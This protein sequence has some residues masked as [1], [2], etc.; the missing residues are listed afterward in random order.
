[1]SN[2]MNKK[3]FQSLT[4]IIDKQKLQFCIKDNMV[5]FIDPSRVYMIVDKKPDYLT[6]EY[7]KKMKEMDMMILTPFKEPMIDIATF[8]N[9]SLG[10][11]QM[12]KYKG[13][14]NG[15]K[16]FFVYLKDKQIYIGNVDD[17]E[18]MVESAGSLNADEKDENL[19][20]L[21]QYDFLAD[22]MGF[23]T[24]FSNMGV[25]MGSIKIYF[26]EGMPLMMENNRFKMYI[27]P[28]DFDYTE[29][30]HFTNKIER[31]MPEKTNINLFE[32]DE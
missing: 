19:L 30:A 3:E 16:F 25:Y 23:I 8:H 17:K 13:K 4:K 10:M 32:T 22:V 9:I 12:E 31:N 21:F 20:A 2:T 28:R 18:A 27:A 7:L 1:M 15:I 24:L 29:I 6:D 11:N 5:M 14:R 26:K